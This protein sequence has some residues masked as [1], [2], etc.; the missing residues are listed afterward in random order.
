MIISKTKP[1]S[2]TGYAPIRRTPRLDPR[3]IME[4]AVSRQPTQGGATIGRMTVDGTWICYTLENPVRE[5]PNATVS[6]WKIDGHTAIPRGRYAVV[7][8]MSAHFNRI[9]PHLMDVP[10]FEGILIHPGNIPAN[11]EGCILVGF[12]IEDSSTIGASRG[13]FAELFIQI[14]DAAKA[15]QKVWCTV[16]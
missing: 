6:S 11:T 9:M 15:G 1:V 13:A 10:G 14:E 7:L 8:A 4:I 3:G 2:N 12:T 16:A 5:I